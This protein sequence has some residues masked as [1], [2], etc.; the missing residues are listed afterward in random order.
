MPDPAGQR[1]SVPK[2]P[3]RNLGH[4]LS[5]QGIGQQSQ[6]PGLR[7]GAVRELAQLQGFSLSGLSTITL[8][9]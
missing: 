1:R 5:E 7:V 2:C 9:L 3:S 4:S 6:L 8:G